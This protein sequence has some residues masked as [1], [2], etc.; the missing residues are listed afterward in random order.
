VS[1]MTEP[2]KVE[3][4]ARPRRDAAPDAVSPDHYFTA[5][6]ASAT[7]VRLL[8]V[9]LAGREVR[10]RVASG[11]FSPGGIDKGTAVLLAK[12]PDPPTQ[13]DLLDLGCG[14]GPLALT[15]G[16]LSPEASVWAVDVNERALDLARANGAALGIQ[17][18]HA[19]RPDGIPPD[20]RFDCIWSN[21][22]IRVGKQALH[23]LLLTWLPRLNPGG[24]A[25]LVV[26]KNLGADSLQRWLLEQLPASRYAVARRASSK[27]FR[28]LSVTRRGD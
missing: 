24:A 25:Y 26:Q 27:G 6:P 14:W 13:G 20:Q 5:Q 28:V 22:P 15:M 19:S 21:P 1:P 18:F 4:T 9:E 2:R 17:G 8:R 12:V 23:Q 10:V 11:I 3:P 16:L 7:D